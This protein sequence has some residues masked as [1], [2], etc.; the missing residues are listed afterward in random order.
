VSQ[1]HP[2]VVG[3]ALCGGRSVRMGRDKAR[4]PWGTGDLLGHAIE[5][6]RAV[7]RDVAI[8]SGSRRRYEDR[9]C[10]VL[11]DVVADRGPIGG[12]EA[13]LAHAGGRPVLLLAVDLPLVTVALL[14]SLAERSPGWDAVVPTPPDGPQPLC[15]VYGPACLPALRRRAGEGEL[16]MTAF[17]PEA[18]VLEVPPSD[19]ARFGDPSALFLN[20]NRPGDLAR[21]RRLASLP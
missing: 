1:G 4:L 9:G 7:S 11:T 21:A 2:E 8:L 3:L 14:L 13:G 19:L 15:A 20:V 5:R 12:L 18:R 16:K 10:P 17:W 6:L